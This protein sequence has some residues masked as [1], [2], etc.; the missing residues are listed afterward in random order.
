MVIWLNDGC[1]M[2]GIVLGGSNYAVF[3][4]FF[5]FFR[6]FDINM[7][8]NITAG[9][10]NITLGGCGNGTRFVSRNR[11][12]WSRLRHPGCNINNSSTVDISLEDGGSSWNWD[13]ILL[14]VF[15][16]LF[17]LFGIV[18]MWRRRRRGRCVR[19]RREREE[20]E[21]QEDEGGVE[22]EETAV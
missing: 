6:L 9:P 11:V 8:F 21:D 10:N 3:T 20:S 14:I 13:S 1:V 22:M 12:H 7:C 17:I 19:R 2:M 4:C 18:G 16:L 15:I 5:E